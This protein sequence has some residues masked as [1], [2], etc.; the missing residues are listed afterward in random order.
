MGLAEDLANKL[1]EDVLKASDIM[2]DEDLPKEIAKLLGASSQTS[3]EAFL[4]AVRVIQAN[5]K[6]RAMLKDRLTA[7]EAKLKD[8]SQ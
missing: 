5:R 8:Q 1:A 6:A 7:F 3:E 2:D 4:T